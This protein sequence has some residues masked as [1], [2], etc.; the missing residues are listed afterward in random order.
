MN[1]FASF[2][3]PLNSRISPITLF[4]PWS[5]VGA[6]SDIGFG[7]GDGSLRGGVGSGNGSLS[8]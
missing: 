7:G 4:D 1:A 6:V 2:L 3:F 8:V 5:W